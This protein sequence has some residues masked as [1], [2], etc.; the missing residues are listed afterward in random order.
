MVAGVAL[1]MVCAFGARRVTV[2]CPPGAV[3]GEIIHVDADGKPFLTPYGDPV[4]EATEVRESWTGY[5]DV[6]RRGSPVP[7]E[8]SEAVGGALL[9]AVEADPDLV[10][11]VDVANLTLEAP[12]AGIS[13]TFPLEASTR[14]RFLQGLDDIGISL[15]HEAEIDSYE[16]T[17]P[18]WLPTTA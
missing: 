9:D 10:I 12:D 3:G 7:V 13:C 5:I 2:V 4:T 16:A 6:D 8:V 18:T 11:T 17:R 14:E 15:R 1:R